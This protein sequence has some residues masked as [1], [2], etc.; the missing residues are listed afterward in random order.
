MENNVNLFELAID[1]R[2]SA[3]KLA[4][5]ELDEQ[6]LIDTLESLGGEL[7][8]KATNTAMLIA[9]SKRAP[10]RSRKPKRTWPRAGRRWKT[11]P[12]ASRIGCW[13]T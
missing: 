4:D 12:H 10:P 13:R 5:M 11:A 7:E 1:Y 6:T 9:I 3:A 2:E 8:A